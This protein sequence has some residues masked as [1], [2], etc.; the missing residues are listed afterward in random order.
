MGEKIEPQDLALRCWR[1]FDN[2]LQPPV[3]EDG[4]Y[5]PNLGK[6]IRSCEQFYKTFS[7]YVASP[8]SKARTLTK[9]LH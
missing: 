9:M 6:N 3:S 7:C 2:V 4:E 5:P 8:F 1:N